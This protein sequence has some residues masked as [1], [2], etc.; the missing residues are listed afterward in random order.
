MA[1][2]GRKQRIAAHWGVIR[3]QTTATKT[4]LR[5]APKEIANVMAMMSSR[6]RM[7][8]HGRKQSLAA[9]WDVISKP[10]TATSLRP[11]VRPPVQL[12]YSRIAWTTNLSK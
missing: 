11:H 12:A 1:A 4:P 6:V 3:K 5:P 9:H 10:M 8:A 2:H 7:V